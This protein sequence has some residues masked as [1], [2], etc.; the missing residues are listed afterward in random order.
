M[1]ASCAHKIKA[2]TKLHAILFIKKEEIAKRFLFIL[3]CLIILENYLFPHIL[4]SL[5]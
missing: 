5:P 3:K 2:W 1:T 4:V